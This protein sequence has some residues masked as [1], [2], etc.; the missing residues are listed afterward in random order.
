MAVV[1]D[2]I[3]FMQEVRGELSKVVWPK[4]NEWLGSTGVVLIFVFFFAIYLGALD[5]GLSK[6]A[7]YIFNLYSEY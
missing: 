2:T 5:F 4:M 3:K 6:L 1:K 7:K